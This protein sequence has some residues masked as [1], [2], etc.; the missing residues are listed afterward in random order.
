MRKRKGRGQQLRR[1]GGYGSSPGSMADTAPQLKRK[2]EPEAE[3]SETPSTDEKEAGVGNGASAP[4]RLPFSGFRV[5]KVLRE[6][7]R[8]KIIFLHGKVPLSTRG[9]GGWGRTRERGNQSSRQS[10]V[11]FTTNH[12]IR[13]RWS[14]HHCDA[15]SDNITCGIKGTHTSRS[16]LPIFSFP[17]NICQFENHV[18]NSPGHSPSITYKGARNSASACSGPCPWK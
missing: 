11:F 4:V 10:A 14:Y 12:I 7:A 17:T 6:S 5:Q 3:E 15:W 13:G 1:A 8:D 2:R 18:L 9:A 16:N